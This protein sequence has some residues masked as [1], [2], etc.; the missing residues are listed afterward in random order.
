MQMVK[1]IFLIILV[2]WFA[3]LMFMPKIDLYY[4]LE[5]ELLKQDI[6][7]NEKSIK[8]G[9]FSLTLTDAEVYIKGINIATIKEINFF[10]LLFYSKIS[11]KTVGLDESLQ[12]FAPQEIE[13]LT[14]VH[15]LLSVYKLFITSSGSFGSVKGKIKL[16]SKKLRIDFTDIKNIDNIKPQLKNDKKGWYYETSF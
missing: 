15:S 10:T 6:M 13:K 14:I 3:I 2:T 8:E 16:K 9:L 4:T 12:S 1:R 5:K 11:I 7:I